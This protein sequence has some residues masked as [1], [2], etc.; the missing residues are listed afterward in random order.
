MDALTVWQ[1]WAWVIGAGLKLVENR[2]WLPSWK[3]LKEGDDIAIH[4]GVT[5]PTRADYLTMKAAAATMGRTTVP[6]LNGHVMGPEY[7]R[8]RIVAV[9]KFVGIARARE[10][11]PEAQRVWWSGPYGWLFADVRQLN[12]GTAPKERGQLGLWGL[13][14]GAERIVRNQLERPE[15]DLWRKTA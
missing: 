6:E 7:G 13:S 2:G 5:S 9:V 8:G 1:P 12:L 14:V 3:R 4:A 11:L 15:G 10:D